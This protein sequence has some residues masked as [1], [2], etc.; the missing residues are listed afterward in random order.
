[1]IT[2]LVYIPADYGNGGGFVRETIMQLK[3][4]SISDNLLPLVFRFSARVGC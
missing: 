4:S 3:S 1:M 2:G